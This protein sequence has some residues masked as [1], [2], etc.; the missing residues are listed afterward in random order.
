MGDTFTWLIGG[1]TVLVG[2]VTI[3]C[4]TLVPVAIL[5]GVG[6]FIYRRSQ[7]ASTARQ[8]AQV[9][10]QTTGTVLFSTIQIRRQARSRSEVPVVS[11]QY[12]VGGQLYQGQRIRAGD[13]F[14]SIRVS[15]DAQKTIARYPAGATVVVFYNPANPAEAALER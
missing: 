11:Y 3:V 10:P 6:Y 8:A 1:G 9:W 14:A 4:T 7:Q 13:Q 2:L 15:G 5:G 12:Q